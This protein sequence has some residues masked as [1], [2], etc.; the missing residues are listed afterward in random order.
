M[1]K[2]K[3]KTLLCQQCY[4]NGQWRDAL[5]GATISVTNPAN[6]YILGTVPD[7]DREEVASAIEAA[8]AAL[9]KWRDKTAAERSLLMRRWFDLIM[10]S[11][12]DLAAIMTAE[13]G[14]P[15]T[16]SAG[17]IAYAASFIEWFAEEGKR[18]YGDTIPT[19]Q[20]DKR[21]IVLKEP[22]GV[23]VAIT[24]WNFPAAMITRKAA[25]AL[26]AGCTM[27][28]KPARTTP[29]SALALA[30]LADRA[31]IPP[32]VFNVVTGQSS[33]ICREFTKNP[34][35]RKLSFTGSTEVGRL[36]MSQCSETVKRISLELGGNAPFIV[37]DDADLDAAVQ[38]AIICKFRN[39]G[40]TCVCTNRIFVQE[41]IY[42]AFVEKFVAAVKELKVGDGFHSDVQQ[43][44]LIDSDAVLK[45]ESYIADALSKGAQLLAGG[46][47]HSLGGTFF[48]PTVLRDVSQEMNI[49]KEETFGP[50]A[51]L[52]KFKTEAE[53]I[54]M[55]NDTEFGLASYLYSRDMMRIW[56]VSERLEYGM[57]GI[58][59]G[60]LST[61][62]APFGGIKQS[63]IGR[64]GSKYGI[65]EYL[66]IKY[67]C[68]GGID[69]L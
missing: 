38:G 50:V 26:A 62:V 2:L 56:R 11:Q 12:T 47:R 64:E 68:M 65:D 60:I 49:A 34:T 31:G 67:L 58:N 45:V 39:S 33:V 25:P 17:E 41:G 5:S 23:C 1:V 15:L 69:G 43:G 3:D 9:P 6:G 59:T 55:A 20:S 18:V 52:F 51:P 46:G 66:E 44:P 63:G 36:L 42:D 19:H 48:Q 30:Q 27:L 57:V 53:V 37:F 24:P 14:K 10:D 40:Q 8:N 7:M 22:V 32:G 4:I 54:Q 13:Q 35:V 21:I 61:A 29:F 28:V 16:E